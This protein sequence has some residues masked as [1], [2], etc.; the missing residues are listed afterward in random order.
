M[1][2]GQRAPCT[3][4]AAELLPFLRVC[5]HCGESILPLCSEDV[6]GASGG[7]AAEFDD[8]FEDEVIEHADS[9][10]AARSKFRAGSKSW[11]K[12]DERFLNAQE[13]TS[14]ARFGKT[15]AKRM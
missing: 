10:R 8:S 6:R 13:Q 11:A 5:P 12:L 7:G 4:C 9:L 1:H 3:A 14:A 15:L 2:E